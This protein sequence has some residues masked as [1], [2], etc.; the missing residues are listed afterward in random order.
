MSDPTSFEERLNTRIA[1]SHGR[2]TRAQED[3]QAAFRAAD[4]EQAAQIR[5][6]RVSA[7][8][9][10]GPPRATDREAPRFV[11]HR[12]RTPVQAKVALGNADVLQ[13]LDTIMWQSFDLSH[14]FPGAPLGQYPVV[15]CETLEEFFTPVLA[16]ADVSD[17][18]REE[19]LA[20]YVADAQAHAEESGGGIF[21]VNLP[22]RGCYV[23]GWLFGFAHGTSPRAALQ[24]PAIFPAI[25]ETVC[26]EKLGHGFIAALTAV[27]Q[28]KTQLG[29]WRF[30][31]ARKFNLRTV[32]SP[33][34]TLLRQKHNLVFEATKF[35]E[36]GW[37]TWIEQI[38]GWL[39]A[40]HGLVDR[41]QAPVRPEAKYT[42]EEVA[43]L[44]D[45]L[46]KRVPR[47]QRPTV[48]RFAQATQLL[49]V[50]TDPKAMDALFPAIQVWQQE[51]QLFD[52]VFAEAFGQ[53][54]L[55]VLGYLLS[56]RLEARLGW[57]NLPYAVAIAGNVTYDLENISLVDLATLLSSDPRLNVD[58]RLAL[59]GTL[60]LLEGQG[61]AA[62]ARLAREKLNLAV[63]ESI[64]A[65]KR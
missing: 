46:Q 59:L 60:Q 14:I 37:A 33:R 56:R 2:Q 42:L 13:R 4:R 8:A 64:Q 51:A 32:D 17:S 16:D 7:S 61:P 38:M 36:E 55:Y 27:G 25:M 15:Y 28:E 58:A 47:E 6:K 30:D 62:L 10:C 24:D 63:P 39:A 1:T 23:N 35:T 20:A 52:E 29:L 21:G 18:T 48:E 43:R 65:S 3:L 44:L 22:G 11:Q 41:D 49:L 57:Q 12:F 45:S 31:W 19:V 40:R 5:A 34:S 53:P 50:N 54:T 9:D 26:H